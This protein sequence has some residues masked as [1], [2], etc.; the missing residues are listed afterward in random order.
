[1]VHLYNLTLQKSGGI[2]A[3]A[4]GNFSAAKAQEI[5]VVRNKVIELLR[6]DDSGR[7]QTVSSMEAFGVVRSICAL[8]LAGANRD[9]LCVGSDSGRVVILQFKKERNAFVKVHQET[10]GKS[11]CRRVVPGQFVCADPKGRAICLGAMERSKLVYVMNRDN[12]AN[13]T[14]SS[15]LEANKSHAITYH[16]CALDC[17]L[18]NPVFAAIELDYGEVDDDPTGE[19]VAE[20]Q[21]HLT[22][23][24][25]DLGLNHVVRKW[26][27]PIDNGANHLI[28]VPGGSDGPGG[29]LVCCENFIIYRHQD[30]EEVRAVIPRRTSLPG[31]RG[32]LIVSSAG[33]KSKKSF[34]FLA[35]SEYGDI[36]KLSIE[37]SGD[38][39]S[40]VKVKYFDTIPPCV[41]MCVLKTGFLFAAS[42]FGNH[43]LY[44]FAG[45]GDDDAVESSSA[46]LMETEQG[47]EPVFFDPRRLT[48]LYPIDKIDSLC[49]IL[50]M[51]AHNLT[52]EDTPQL[53]T[54]CGTGARSSLRILRQGIGMNELAMSSLP[55]QP[56][57]IFTVKK[58]SSDQ[59]D[60]Y[61]VVSF[62]NATLVLAI[63]D[64]VTEVSDSGIL[65]TT[66]TLQV[67]LM[68]DDSLLQVHAGG[69]RHI[70]ADKR[71]NEWRTPGRKQISKCTCN[72]KQV[73]I[74]LTGGEVI[75]FELDSAGQLIEVEKLETNGDIACVDIAPVPEGALRSRFL[76]MGSYDGTVRVMSLNSD[77]CLQT[78]AVQAL[79]GSTPSSLLIL[80]TAGTESLQG[81]LLLNVGMANGVLMRA[82][83]DQVSGQLSD[84]RVRFLG[85]RAPKLVRTSVRGES[86][87][88]ALSSRPW[89]GYSEKGTFV[90]S[91][92]SY[93][94]LEEVCSFSSEACPEGVVAISNQ[95][96]RIASVERLGENFHQTTIKLRYT[97]R[98]MS[99]NPDTKMVALIESDQCSVPVGER[100]S[101]EAT[102]ADEA[103]EANGDEDEL[104]M[105]P[106]EQYGA[107]KSSPGTW[108]ACV[109]I[110]DPKD[111]K[112]QY[113]LE[114]GKNESAIS[115]CH[116]Y[117]TGPNELL[118]AV[119]TAQNLTFA[120][121][122]CDGG[123][124]HL[125]RYG[126]DSKT[127]SLVHSTPTE[128]PVGALCGY[129]GHLLAG[130][131]NSLRL[132]DFGKKKLLRK[133][134]NRNFPNFITTIHA[135]SDR[136]YV[137][138]VQESIHF[139]KYK[140]DEGSMYIFADDTKPAYMTAA[141][142]LDF[143]TLA[144]ADK[145]GNIFV[146]RLP[147]DISEDMDEDPTGGKNIYSQGVLN[148]APNKSETCA[149]TFIGETVCALTKGALQ[150]GGID[151]IMYGTFLGGIGALVPFQT[152]SEIDFFITLEMHMRQEASSIVGRDHMAFRSYYAPVKNVIDGDLCEQ[153]GAL[154]PEVQRRI[155]EDMD[156]TPGEILKRLE[157][158]RAIA[159]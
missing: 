151:I 157:Q 55:G 64:T 149:R 38:K 155:A 21:K 29:V 57:A 22:Y 114:L 126:T 14:I 106:V 41:S 144:G 87:L 81:S 59:Y 89:L 25:L 86:A 136:I 8:R 84:M 139:V 113:V 159:V 99:A 112:S 46:S 115:I 92:I 10:F 17:G 13:L 75:Y 45:I 102:S 124:I 125:Y 63:G 78:L 2:T 50:D 158:I 12:E 49:P 150:P 98:A 7:V 40:E 94:A 138:D 20:T 53:Y 3:A 42:E 51:Q 11:G 109:R 110:I 74:A 154:A 23:Y 97:P 76:A 118:L 128:G 6:P 80:Q 141:L 30:H 127:L 133:L 48:N 71:I 95:T 105:L 67:C 90:L 77:D 39:V 47:Y 58:K 122:N 85:T 132:Y 79:K 19:V 120:P 68:N 27:E 123:F 26:S 66:M 44:Q 31:D 69:L 117:L 73:V 37:Y 111:A 152:R 70:K 15:P 100:E 83:L 101:P 121:R 24:E 52:E 147:K 43:A 116:V 36:Y 35:Q 1:M 56:N 32:V 130:V 34:F 93:V 9:Y 54:L 156:R 65:G 153:F 137:G 28:P 5:V 145:F 72:S 88:V 62:L 33:H 60:G 104:N 82:T 140:A 18:D 16:M 61:I 4:Y 135:A 131:N 148:G 143:D 119:G 108:A 142:P 146:N 134:E 129:R 107:P 96:L 91:P 103:S